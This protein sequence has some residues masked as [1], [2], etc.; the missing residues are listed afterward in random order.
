MLANNGQPPFG[1][2]GWVY[3][4]KYDGWRAIA[5]KQGNGVALISRNMPSAAHPRRRQV[6]ALDVQAE[7]PRLSPMRVRA[8]EWG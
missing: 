7:L 5:Y 8:A 1:R 6:D 4:E 2:P 3:E